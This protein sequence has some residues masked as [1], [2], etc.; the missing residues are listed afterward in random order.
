MTTKTARM[1]A[2]RIRRVEIA[3]AISENPEENRN[4]INSPELT[5]FWIALETVDNL[6]DK[7]DLLYERQGNGKFADVLDDIDTSPDD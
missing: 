5:V 4:I 7:I 6:I 2:S 1:M 3:I